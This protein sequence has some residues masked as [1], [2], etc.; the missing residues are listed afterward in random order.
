[1]LMD[2]FQNELSATLKSRLISPSDRVER[3][4]TQ[5]QSDSRST[6]DVI[7]VELVITLKRLFKMGESEPLATESIETIVTESIL[8]T[9]HQQIIEIP[10]NGLKIQMEITEAVQIRQ[11]SPNVKTEIIPILVEDDFTG[12]QVSRSWP[13]LVFEYDFTESNIKTCSRRSKV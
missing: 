8:E 13:E 6:T 5:C 11:S 9:E 10:E 3:I 2:S 4:D 7:D 1:M 12:Y